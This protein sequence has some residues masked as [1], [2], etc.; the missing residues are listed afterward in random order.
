[1]T[2]LREFVETV[3]A[4]AESIFRE[5]GRVRPTYFIVASDG[6]VLCIPA[7]PVEKDLAME[8]MRNLFAKLDT[9]R[10]C[11]TDEV[12]L[13]RSHDDPVKTLDDAKALAKSRPQPKDHPDRIEC[14]M[15]FA[16]DAIEG[17]IAAYRRIER[18]PDGNG[19]LGPLSGADQS[20]TQVGGRMTGLLPRGTLQ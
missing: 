7:P 4:T 20:P 18:D 11:F 14:L 2:P 10:Y 6:E 15:L 13:V 3:S 12:W 16:E 8:I 5:A 1:M 19:T 17:F 9:K